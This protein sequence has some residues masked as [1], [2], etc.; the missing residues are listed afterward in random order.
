MPPAHLRNMLDK[1]PPLDNPEFWQ[2]FHQC[3][4]DSIMETLL[5]G[6]PHE[7]QSEMVA[8]REKYGMFG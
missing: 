1:T 6:L 7:Q 4:L 5:M 2:E 8:L 3:L